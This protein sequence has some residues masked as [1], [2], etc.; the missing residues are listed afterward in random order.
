MALSDAFVVL[1]VMVVAQFARFGSVT[2]YS[3][4]GP[5]APPYLLVT[6]GIGVAWWIA[7]G[8]TR[9]REAWILGHGPHEFQRVVQATGGTFV[10]VAVLA[11]LT[12]WDISRG[13]LLIAGPVGIVTLLIYRGMWRKWIHAQRDAGNLQA[14]VLIVGPRGV[15]EQMI[16]R[17]IRT[18]RAGLS[19]VGVCLPATPGEKLPDAVAG[20]PVVGTIDVAADAALR[21]GVEY[22]ILSGNDAMSLHESRRLSWS[23]EGTG[24]ELVVAPAMVDIAGP[25]IQMSPVEGVPLMHVDTPTFDGGKYYLKYVVDRMIAAV[26]LAVALV[27]MLLIAL[28]IKVTAPGPALFRQ[29][30]IGQNGKPFTMLKFRSMAVGAESRLSEAMGGSVGVF[31][32]NRNDPRVTPLGSRLRRYSLDELPQLYN[33][34]VGHMAIVGPR[35]QVASEVSQYTELAGRRLLVKPGLTGLWQVSGRSALTPE[36]SI[37]LDAYYAENWSLIGDAMIVLRT[38]RAVVGH[39]G[40]Y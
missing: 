38:A 37:R 10:A 7:L 26:G 40:A 17:L 39:R 35:P 22:I 23:L 6:V 5:A 30:R 19:V 28:L 12:Q 15:S 3:V 14:Q 27:P 9:S 34:L 31:Y 13:Y 32:K 2:D 1:L 18:R 11:F 24:I 8:M 4:S 21:L 29:E 25:R 33:V 16:E 20:V 36:E